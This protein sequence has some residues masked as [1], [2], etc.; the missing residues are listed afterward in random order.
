MSSIFL[1][2]I[3]LKDRKRVNLYEKAIKRLV[4]PG[5]IVID[6]G[7]GTGIMGFL[8]LKYGAKRIFAIEKDDII[9]LAR[10]IALEN[11]FLERITFI[12]KHSFHTVLPKRADLLIA[13]LM[14]NF[15][16]GERIFES[17]YNAKKRFLKKDARLIPRLLELFVCPIECTKFYK[18]ELCWQKI[19]G[20]KMD[21]MK[22]IVQNQ[23][24]PLEGDKKIA[25]S[26]PKRLYRFKLGK[27]LSLVTSKLSFR[28]SK[29]GDFCG[30]M[31]W[32]R[33]ELAPDVWLD[34]SSK[35]HWRPVLLPVEPLKRLQ[36]GDRIYSHF[37][38]GKD[39]SISWNVRVLR[40]GRELLQCRH[41]TLFGNP[42]ILAGL[43]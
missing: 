33:A 21:L 9:H 11:N 15:A 17:I 6:L 40:N 4:R 39:S 22:K 24:L 37:T 32:F 3:L 12:H 1:H 34:S 23:L 25:L 14:G 16:F 5:D 35:T 7:C 13:E 19:H 42:K 41:S 26:K 8:A 43:F 31:G 36:K 20:V 10:A 38:I 28:V 30:F 18:K 27:P 29:S 2:K